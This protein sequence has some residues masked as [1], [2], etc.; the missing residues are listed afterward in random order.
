MTNN[1]SMHTMKQTQILSLFFLLQ[2]SF[3]LIFLC[4]K[5]IKRSTQH[6]FISFSLSHSSVFFQTLNY[7]DRLVL[8]SSFSL[9]ILW[10]VIRIIIFMYNICWDCWC[11]LVVLSLAHIFSRLVKGNF[12]AQKKEFWTK[13][14]S[15]KKWNMWKACSYCVGSEFVMCWAEQEEKKAA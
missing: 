1:L 15:E 4:T 10:H 2:F 13:K 8:Y 9:S 6:Y 12:I 11:A 5:N 3:S 14:S 7:W